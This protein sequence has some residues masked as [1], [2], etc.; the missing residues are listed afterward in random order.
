MYKCKKTITIRNG[1]HAAL[2]RLKDEGD[3]FSD[4]IDRLTD[5]KTGDIRRFAGGLKDSKILDSLHELT[6]E[7]R[8]SGRSRISL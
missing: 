3:S 6:K 2:L 1:T 5:E 7:G 4:V 8:R